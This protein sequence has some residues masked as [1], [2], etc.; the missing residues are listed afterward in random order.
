M[1]AYVYYTDSD[2][3]NLETVDE[4]TSFPKPTSQDGK[5]ESP[6]LLMADRGNCAFTTKIRHAQILGAAA[7]LVANNECTCGDTA[8]QEANNA[9]DCE[10]ELPPITGDGSEGD[11]SIP[12]FLVDRTDSTTMIKEIKTDHV[13]MMLE[14]GWGFRPPS[15]VTYSFFS[16]PHDEHG[17]KFL[18]MLKHMAVAFNG[19]AVF[20]PHQFIHSGERFGCTNHEIVNKAESCEGMCTNGGRYCSPNHYMTQA[21]DKPPHLVPGKAIVTESLRRLCIWDQYGKADGIGIEY[22]N[23]LE[24]FS[25]RCG[26]HPEFFANND[27]ALDA[28]HHANIDT[29]KITT[30]MTLSGNVD[31]DQSNGFLDTEI[32]AQQQYGVVSL[33]NVFVNG[34]PLKGAINP[35]TIFYDICMNFQSGQP[36]YPAV[37]QKC[38]W[39]TTDLASCL[40]TG[41]DLPDD[42]K[43]HDD[44]GDKKKKK[45]KGHGAKAFWITFFVLAFVG[46]GGYWYYR[47]MQNERDSIIGDYM[48]FMSSQ[49]GV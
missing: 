46:G 6:F 24:E 47:K 8:C 48:P 4:S 1:A 41:G 42:N 22:W 11:I 28:S 21:E 33:P 26:Q 13:K 10:A 31:K 45:K 2:L 49:D 40:G 18:P 36:T 12:S 34:K 44:G 29:D 15:K 23:Y 35:Y 17:G 19:S 39:T 20:E 3:C 7:L 14:V 9:Q 37:C 5:W 16:S 43:K 30:C 27:C 25:T 32:K 38:M